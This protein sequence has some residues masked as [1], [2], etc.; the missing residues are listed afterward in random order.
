[1]DDMAIGF[2][3]YNP[4]EKT[5]ERIR[6]CI[7]NSYK[8][9]VFD[10]TPN[11]TF[12]KDELKKNKGIQ[13]YT[14]DKN[15][16]LGISISMITVGAYYDNFTYL[17][18]FDQDTIFNLDTLSFIGDFY[19]NNVEKLP[20]CAAIS[21]QENGTNLGAEHVQLAI[22]SG[23]L[24]VLEELKTIGWHDMSYFVDG[25][26]YKF[27]LDA[28]KKGFN[29]YKVGNVPGF[30]H[31]S[32]QDDVELGIFG[33]KLKV[34]SYPLFRIRDYVKALTRLCILS[35][36]SFKYSFFFRFFKQLF[37]FVIMQFVSR[38]MRL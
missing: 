4:T 13:Y 9:Y 14:L 36:A 3:L 25:V 32:E 34:R 24:F 6:I 22:N 27:C 16:G 2:V 31:S 17:L 35:I 10:N 26:D 28:S 30:D 15:V 18:F 11:T 23:S 7:A 38:V 8:V 19:K 20:N 21:F 33:Y 1:M 29:I 37:L 5:L 12:F